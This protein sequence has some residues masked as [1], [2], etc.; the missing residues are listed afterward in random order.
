MEL[1]IQYWDLALVVVCALVGVGYMAYKYTTLPTGKKKDLIREGLL[2]LVI[3][4]EQMYGSKTGK[5]KFEYVYNI[6]ANRFKWLKHIP[7]S[8]VEQMINEAL[9]EMRE[10]LEKKEV[11]KK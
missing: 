2:E 1:L 8:V 9:D 4:A 5:T 11:L 7:M 3:Q 10:M 6:L